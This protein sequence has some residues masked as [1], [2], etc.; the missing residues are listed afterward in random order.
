MLI[1]SAVDSPDSVPPANVQLKLDCS[2]MSRPQLKLVACK[3]MAPFKEEFILEVGRVKS[4][5]VVVPASAA[6]QA[7]G[8]R[9]RGGATGRGLG[10]GKSRG[11]GSQLQA[12]AKEQE[13]APAADPGNA[14]HAEE[15]PEDEKSGSGT[16]EAGVPQSAGDSEDDAPLAAGGP[17]AP[18][19]AAGLVTP[20]GR[21]RSRSS[22]RGGGR[23]TT[24]GS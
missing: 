19:A 17:E 9:G 12:A 10:R 4:L 15:Q 16:A 6:E 21:A 1:R 2:I 14:I 7:K 24:L 11:R 23:S 22:E 18:L 5:R 20:K 3:P 13:V 8:G